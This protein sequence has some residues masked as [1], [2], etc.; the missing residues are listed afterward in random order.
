MK[1]EIKSQLR[2]TSKDIILERLLF[3]SLGVDRIKEKC[4]D[5]NQY[6]SLESVSHYPYY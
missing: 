2:G 1:F 4:L 3:T 6:Y 5:L